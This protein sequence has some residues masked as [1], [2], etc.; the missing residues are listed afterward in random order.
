ML[1]G[2]LP[3]LAVGASG[4]A[5]TAP[6]TQEFRTPMIVRQI[7]MDGP[8]VAYAG[9]TSSRHCPRIYVWNVL[10]GQRT[11]V[12]HLRTCNVAGARRR[13]PARGLDRPHGGEHRGDRQAATSR[14]CRR[15]GAAAREDRALRR[16]V[17]RNPRCWLGAWIQGLAGSDSLLAVSR[18]TTDTKTDVQRFTRGGLDVIGSDGLRRV[19]AG[20]DG[21][22]AACGRFGHTSPCFAQ[23]GTIGELTTYQ[24]R[25]MSPSTPAPESS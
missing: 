12:S 1:L 8:R 23:R 18:W 10:N 24:A 4:G 25:R 16:G 21:I 9:W 2:V 20:Q 15:Q 14:P 13:R 22:V 17:L 6:R 3:A 7:A 11:A 5:G 19:V